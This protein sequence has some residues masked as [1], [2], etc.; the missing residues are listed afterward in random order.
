VGV[1]RVEALKQAEQRCVEQRGKALALQ[2]MFTGV[3][4]AGLTDDLHTNP[5]VSQLFS[6]NGLASDEASVRVAFA[7]AQETHS[8]ITASL[9]S[10]DPGA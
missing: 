3:V 6:C 10:S 9:P 1:R 8:L 5:L 2:L 4:P 7:A